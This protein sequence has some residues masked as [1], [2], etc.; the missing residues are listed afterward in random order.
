M[1]ELRRRKEDPR[2]EVLSILSKNEKA[3]EI[4]ERQEKSIAGG[5]III[6]QTGMLSD[7]KQLMNFKRL[8]QNESPGMAPV[9]NEEG[10]DVFFER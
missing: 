1:R 9:G 2:E 10:R 8:S 3:N 6:E 4:E 5:K 7:I